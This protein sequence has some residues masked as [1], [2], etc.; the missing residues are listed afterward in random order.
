MGVHAQGLKHRCK[1]QLLPSFESDE[2]GAEFHDIGGLDGIENNA[3]HCGLGNGLRSLRAACELNDTIHP[4][5][6]FRGKRGVKKVAFAMDAS[7]DRA[8]DERFFGLWE[9]GVAEGS[10][11]AL[12]R[13]TITIAIGMN[14]LNELRAFYRFSP[15]IHARNK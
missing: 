6:C 13:Q 11:D 4:G 5:T 3:I 1:T 2:F 10:D 14:E 8:G 9:F 15:K 7:L 12:A